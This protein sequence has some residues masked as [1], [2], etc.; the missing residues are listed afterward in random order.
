[1][2]CFSA[3]EDRCSLTE[4]LLQGFVLFA[5]SNLNPS[6][7]FMYMDPYKYVLITSIK[8][9]SNPSKTVR[10][11]LYKCSIVSN[12]LYT[13]RRWATCPKLLILL[14][15]V[16]LP[17][18]PFS[19]LT[20][21]LFFSFLPDFMVRDLHHFCIMCKATLEIILFQFHFSCLCTHFI[22]ISIFSCTC[23][24]SGAFC[25]FST[26]SRVPCLLYTSIRACCSLCVS[27]GTFCLLCV[28]TR[29]FCL[30]CV[31]TR[32][33]YLLYT[34][35]WGFSFTMCLYRGFLSTMYLFR[36]FLFIVYI[37]KG[38]LSYLFFSGASS[39]ACV[40]LFRRIMSL[41]R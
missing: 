30:F 10:A 16:I 21:H 27:T 7:I 1:M 20:N 24:S 3:H 19:I 34:S 29:A 39:F 26:F 28:F 15:S 31:F 4:Y 25:A 37:Y 17:A 8:R 40:L 6:K 41:S 13:L 2:D 22:E 33:F 23:A 35:T 18:Y 12:K 32:A 38:L 9:T 14:I 5:S 36:D 11:L